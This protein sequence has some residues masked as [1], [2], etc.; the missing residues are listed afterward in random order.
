MSS[1]QQLQQAHAAAAPACTW[2]AGRSAAL[3]PRPRPGASRRGARPSLI[4]GRL[5]RER[6]VAGSGPTQAHGH[7][8][9]HHRGP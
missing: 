2:L 9:C 5:A 1:A 3:H 6:R 4:Q 8:G 7:H